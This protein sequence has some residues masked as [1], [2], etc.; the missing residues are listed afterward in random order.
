MRKFFIILFILA[1]SFQA[2]AFY[3]ISPQPLSQLVTESQLIIRGKVISTGRVT[4]TEPKNSW[5]VDYAII[6]VTEVWQGSIKQKNVK[7]YFTLGM[8]CPQ[9]GV[10]FDNEDVL[11]FLDKREKA[12][13]YEVHALSYGVK[14]ELN[15]EGFAAYKARVSEM[16]DILKLSPGSEKNKRMTEWLV[17]CAENKATRWEGTYELSGRK[18][19]MT[20][21]KK[22]QKEEKI[23]ID[24]SSKQRMRLFTAFMKEDTLSYDELELADIVVQVDT[25]AVL[26]KLK[27]AL[28]E[29]DTDGLY[30]ADGIMQRISA[31][32]LQPELSNIYKKISSLYAWEE[33]NNAERL[34]LYQQF[35]EVQK[36]TPCPQKAGKAPAI[37]IG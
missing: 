17:S 24:M 23:E 10:F 35:L 15:E 28:A 9:P 11:A 19:T 30:L 26:N 34:K 31:V 14:H 16:Q 25:C 8:I 20:V 1:L 6:A 27:T 18:Y 7:V 33:K 13:G 22:N 5:D 32:C 4:D 29:V 21:I 37:I 36:I 2:V 3:P 12:D